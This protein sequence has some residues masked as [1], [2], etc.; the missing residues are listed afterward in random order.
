MKKK[1]TLSRKTQ[2][3]I[4]GVCLAAI[5]L[6][7][8]GL[9]A[10]IQIIDTKTLGRGISVCS[11]DVSGLT[12]EKATQKIQDTF[13]N[14]SIIFVEDGDEVF[15]TT[16]KELGYTLDKAAL[17][18]QLKELKQQRSQNRRL[19]SVKENYEI[20]LQIQ[21]NAEQLQSVLVAD[22]FGTKTRT[23]STDASIQYSEEDS[24]FILISEVQGNQIDEAK[25]QAYVTET[26]NTEF[27]DNPLVGDVTLTLGTNVYQSP[28]ASADE[29]MQNKLTGLNALL[30]NY[31]SASITYTFGSTEETIDPATIT[32][33]IK[34][35][36]SNVSI[37]EE[38]V[39]S[40]I[41]NLAATYNTIYVPRTFHTSYGNDVTIE[42]NEYGFQIDQ[43]GEF[44]QLLEDLKNGSP[45]KRDPVYSISGM[46]RNG[47]DDLAGSYIEVSLDNQHLWLYKDGA[48]I[49]ETDIISGAPGEETETYRGAWPIAYKASPFTLSSDQ[50]GYEIEVQY[51]MPFV[52]GQGL[53]DA[54]WQS[55][56]GGNSYRT[57]AGSHG[58]VNL[59]PDQAAVI[60]NAIDGGYPIIIY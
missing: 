16:L 42:S 19:I 47:T 29:K 52:Y 15:R 53:H 36:Q 4:L 24:K 6:L 3:I 46:Q 40:Y 2:K 32:S 41:Q 30:Q 33:W 43:D 55:S 39:R 38:A 58:C 12:V 48:L 27:Q 14:R 57:G 44:N 35:D 37:D 7:S 59:P 25:L 9:F 21:E 50:Y 18:E 26:L 51:W 17:S 49:T 34:I 8:I 10:Y 13:E 22:N 60:Y 54:S 56:F 45:V 5:V 11:L 20:N 1:I 23:D 28:S 31:R